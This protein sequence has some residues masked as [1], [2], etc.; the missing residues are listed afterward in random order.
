MSD[1]KDLA[2]SQWEDEMDEID[3]M[4]STP[5]LVRHYFDTIAPSELV[6]QTSRARMP[7][8]IG[9]RQYFAQHGKLSEK[10]RW[11]LA[12]WVAKR[13]LEHS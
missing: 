13:D 12:F 4:R 2:P 5:S 3:W 9:I 7:L 1:P 6:A 8:I 11:C 10:Q